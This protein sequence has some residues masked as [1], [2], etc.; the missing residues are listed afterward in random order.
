M[1]AEPTALSCF[2][3]IGL[4]QADGGHSV[5]SLRDGCIDIALVSRRDEEAVR[6][7]PGCGHAKSLISTFVSRMG[8]VPL[9]AGPPAPVRPRK[10]SPSGVNTANGVRWVGAGGAASRRGNPGIDRLRPDGAGMHH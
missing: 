4:C 1:S 7:L 10:T 6:A 5:G 9:R 2:M 8:L 3:V